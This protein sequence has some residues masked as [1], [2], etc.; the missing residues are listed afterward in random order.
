MWPLQGPWGSPVARGAVRR[1]SRPL[2]VVGRRAVV[3]PSPAAAARG[4]PSLSF[5]SCAAGRTQPP[6]ARRLTS[7]SRRD[8]SSSGR[9]ARP[10]IAWRASR[11]SQEGTHVSPSVGRGARRHLAD[12]LLHAAPRPTTHG[13]QTFAPGSPPPAPQGH[14]G[15]SLA[16][17]ARHLPWRRGPGS[18]GCLPRLAM[19][20]L[21]PRPARATLRSRRQFLERPAAPKFDPKFEALAAEQRLSAVVA[22]EGAANPAVLASLTP[23]AHLVSQKRIGRPHG[24]VCFAYVT[25]DAMCV[26][27]GVRGACGMRMQRGTVSIH[28]HARSLQLLLQ[29]VSQASLWR[30]VASLCKACGARARVL[31]AAHAI[32]RALCILDLSSEWGHSRP[33]TAMYRNVYGKRSMALAV[34]VCT[35]Q[36]RHSARGGALDSTARC[37]RHGHRIAG[38]IAGAAAFIGAVRNRSSPQH[39]TAKRPNRPPPPPGPQPAQPQFPMSPPGKSVGERKAQQMCARVCICVSGVARADEGA[40]IRA[41]PRPFDF[42]AGK[43]SIQGGSIT[44]RRGSVR[45]PPLLPHL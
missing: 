6:S 36:K 41:M 34:R 33:P 7:M 37:E 29:R 21:E 15:V 27:V 38:G 4:H 16:P 35:S 1:P 12:A 19:G 31:S 8:G 13:P 18:A 45:P 26:C 25:L 5:F 17:G 28:M 32:Y 11:R 2:S 9:R 3:A 42:E 20:P 30:V 44:Q 14:E 40:S 22:D 10:S 23:Y 43:I 39:H 24:N